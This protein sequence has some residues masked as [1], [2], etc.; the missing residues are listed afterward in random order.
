MYL[1]LQGEPICSVMAGVT[2]HCASAEDQW[3]TEIGLLAVL[4]AI[5]RSANDR[6]VG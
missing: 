4:V 1:S 5:W 2:A 3:S 6:L